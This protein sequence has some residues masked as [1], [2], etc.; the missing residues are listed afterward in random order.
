[1]NLMRGL[2]S[3]LVIFLLA[4]TLVRAGEPGF[5]TPFR[6]E[7]R[8]AWTMDRKVDSKPSLTWSESEGDQGLRFQSRG[9]DLLS[10]PF[11]VGTKPFEFVAD[12][13]ITEGTATKWPRYK[14]VNIVIGSA[15]VEEMTEDD[16]AVVLSVIQGGVR[17]TVRRGGVWYAKPKHDDNYTFP[18]APL[19]AARHLTGGMGSTSLSWPSKS[20][21]GRSLRFHVRRTDEDVIQFSIYHGDAPLGPWWTGRVKLPES[22]RRR[23]LK[24]VTIHTGRDKMEFKNLAKTVIAPGKAR[25][26]VNGV[27][28]RMAGRVLSDEE[29]PKWNHPLPNDYAAS[30]GEPPSLFFDDDGRASFRQKLEAPHLKPYHAL[31]REKVQAVVEKLKKGKPTALELVAIGYAIDRKKSYLS[32][33]KKGI[34]YQAGVSDAW[35]DDGPGRRRQNLALKTFSA[36][37]F[38][39]LSVAYATIGHRL[40]QKLRRGV[41]LELKRFLRHYR[42][43]VQAGAWWYANGSQNGSNTIGVAGGCAG[44]S[45]LA[46][47]NALPERA[48]RIRDLAIRTIKNKYRAVRP[49]GSS[50]EGPMY[51]EYGTLY[52]VIFARALKHVRGSD[53]GLLTDLHVDRADAYAKLMIGGDGNALVFNDTQPFLPGLAPIVAGASITEKPFLRWLS[54]HIVAKALERGKFSYSRKS[55]L[56]ALL[57]RSRTP[58]PNTMPDLPTFKVMH[59]VEQGVLRSD[60]SLTPQLMTAVKGMGTVHTHHANQDQSSFVLYARGDALLIDPGYF[61]GEPTDHSLVLPDVKKPDKLQ[62]DEEAHAPVSGRTSGSIRV[63]RVDATNAYRKGKKGAQ[64]LSSVRRIVVQVAGRATVV[65]DDVRSSKKNLGVVSRFQTGFPADVPGKRRFHVH[66]NNADLH[67]YVFGPQPSIQVQG[68]HTFS[69]KSWFYPVYF[70]RIDAAW[71]TVSVRR[72]LDPGRPAVTVLVPAAAGAS[73]TP[74]EP[75]V[76]YKDSKITVRLDSKRTVRFIKKEKRWHVNGS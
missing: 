63:L 46:M 5:E 3:T 26:K 73:E 67:A 37:R 36:H 64:T 61:E 12:L 55:I 18:G 7:D 27:V 16:W 33:L 21:E 44:L 41:E 38:V 47:R 15:P 25:L 8:S 39:G 24:R 9:M 11:E 50:V 42:E 22:V 20:L 35:A 74:S 75:E 40:S 31:L 28:R 29:S 57:Y 30:Q 71:H 23:P 48:E 72:T 59:G 53:H 45:A 1:M 58:A 60:G 14:G 49:D 70:D 62:L 6:L 17:A 76:Q 68:P 34:R 56:P 32:A 51:W 2:V 66:G 69:E 54:D 19:K 4:S 52:P 65:L 10:R 43:R 13:E